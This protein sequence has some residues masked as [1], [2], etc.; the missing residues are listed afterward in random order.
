M[1]HSPPVIT[2]QTDP[3]VAVPRPAVTA[4]PAPSLRE[5]PTS[6]RQL[7]LLAAVLIVGAA[8]RVPTFMARVLS[9]D[10]AIYATTASE[11]A[12]GAVLYR[13]VVDHKPPGIYDVYLASILALGP[14]NTHG[15]HAAVVLS[16]LL[17]AVLLWSTA[18]RLYREEGVDLAAALLF[19]VF[20]TAMF[21]YDSL[22]ANC[23]LLLL[24]PQA[25]GLWWLVRRGDGARRPWQVYVGAGVLTG[26]ATIIKYQGATFLAVIAAAAALEARDGRRGAG[27]AAGLV[28]GAT[29]AAGLVPA[30]YLLRA[31]HAGGLD[32]LWYWFTFNFAYIRAGRSGLQALE[33]GITRLAIVGGTAAFLPYA[34]GAAG[35]WRAVKEC[36]ALGAGRSATELEPGVEARALSLTWL[37]SSC[38]AVAA[39]GRYFGHYFHH[40]LPALCL[41]ASG[42][43]VRVWTA[44]RGL[45]PVVGALVAVPAVG[46][47]AAA[48]TPSGATFGDTNPQPP[49]GVLASRLEALSA[50]DDRVFVWGNSPQVYALAERPMGTRFSFCNY[51]TGVSPGT[52]TEKGEADAR[53]NVVRD[54][55]GMLF[56][57][58]DRR[59]PRWIVDAAAAG[60]D[61]Y[62][63]FPMTRYPRLSGYVRAHYAAR[64][65]VAGTVIYERTTP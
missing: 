56:D 9:D 3:G 59:R 2:F 43:L 38:V 29:A 15:A 14:Y 31:W 58:L 60:W 6:R 23:E 40:V 11:M 17:T 13:D 4:A 46:F 30:L 64:L 47:L 24:L 63:A 41:L 20:S 21:R 18:R 25:A 34:L 10:E 28:L 52:P 48:A 44:G 22:A 57:D 26:L 36:V 55:W 8:L 1:L 37:A 32:A 65:R 53:P 12:R 49:Y 39:G 35:A 62:G 16:V 42:P 50:L 7:A 45:R 27:R 19:T 54:A 61:G 33:F 5:K 51:L